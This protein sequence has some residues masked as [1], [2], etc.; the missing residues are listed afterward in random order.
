VLVAV[1]GSVDTDTI[2]AIDLVGIAA[3]ATTTRAATVGIVGIN[4]ESSLPKNQHE[5][6]I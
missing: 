2:V 4:R 6:H 1:G 5:V 3:T